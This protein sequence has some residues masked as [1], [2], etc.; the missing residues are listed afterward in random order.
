M[1]A[2]WIALIWLVVGFAVAGMFGAAGWRANRLRENE[3]A[4]QRAGA[5]VR[6]LPHARSARS[7]LARTEMMNSLKKTPDKQRHVA[8]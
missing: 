1:T 6:Y 5:E 2:V 3:Q 4:P 8:A 7:R